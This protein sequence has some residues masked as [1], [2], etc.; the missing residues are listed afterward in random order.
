[1]RIKRYTPAATE[2]FN[3]IPSDVGRPLHDITHRLDYPQLADDTVAVFDSLQLIER[4]IRGINGRHFLTRLSPYRTTDDRI[5]GAVLT[6]VD[7]SALRRAEQLVRSSEERLHLAA[8]STNDFAIIVQDMDGRVA[9]WNK[10]AER[11][12]VTANRRW[13][14]KRS[15]ACTCRKS[16][17]PT[18]PPANGAAHRTTAARKTSAGTS[19]R[20]A[21]GSIAA[22]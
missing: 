13:S 21:R 16:V 3:V 15:T 14:D 17:K 6:I 4:E 7:I 5:E 11:F 1:M 18:N 12:S 9:T 22:V 10:G 2:L 8:Q 19:I 20:A